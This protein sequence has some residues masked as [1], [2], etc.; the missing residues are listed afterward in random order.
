MVS[1]EVQRQFA[2]RGVQMIHPQFGWRALDENCS[3]DG[4]V[5]SK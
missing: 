1:A 2:E 4:R 5:K 3:M